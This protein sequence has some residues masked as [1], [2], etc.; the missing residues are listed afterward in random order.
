VEFRGLR[1]GRVEKISYKLLDEVDIQEIP[2]LI[3]L[4][5]RLLETHFPPAIL[6]EGEQGVRSA[7]TQGLRASLKSSNLLTGQL[8]LDLDFFPQEPLAQIEEHEGRLILPTIHTGF[9][10]LQDQ[11]A[12]LLDKLNTLELEELVA[13]LNRT[14]ATAEGTLA[15]MDRSLTSE[16]GLL[17]SAQTTL[18]DIESAV[19]SLGAVLASEDTQ[20]LPGDLRA[21]MTK[22]QESL[23]PLSQEGT[24]YGDLRRTLDELRGAIRSLDRM[25]SVI[26]E[27]PNSLLF[28]K[29]QNTRKEPRARR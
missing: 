27:K 16:D 13:T 15:K 17:N 26:A 9:S 1:I 3:Q 24:V 21:T 4:D 5:N 28:G 8:Y 18:K 2:V 20:A 12:A 6:D 22:I 25:T 29:D 10:D 14:I 11:V 7:M 19:E 23:K